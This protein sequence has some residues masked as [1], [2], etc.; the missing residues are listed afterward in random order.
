MK[1]LTWYE[2]ENFVRRQLH[3]PANRIITPETRL[4]DLHIRS[5]DTDHFV[6]LFFLR[7]GIERG[8]YD[9]SRYFPEK[10]PWPVRLARKF[11]SRRGK[12]VTRVPITMSMLTTAARLGEWRTES[13][14]RAKT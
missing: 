2:V 4:Q 1:R 12:G 7:F 14:E 8:D 5:D 13:V 3:E 9:I 6:D 11:T 10:G